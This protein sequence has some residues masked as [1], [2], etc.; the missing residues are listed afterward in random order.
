V[1]FSYLLALAATHRA[2]CVDD[3]GPL[4]A[5][6]IFHALEAYANYVEL[7]PGD[8]PR[9]GTWGR[10]AIAGGIVRNPAGD[11][12]A[13]LTCGITAFVPGLAD[14]RGFEVGARGADVVAAYGDARAACQD[15]YEGHT[16]C[17]FGAFDPDEAPV[18][19]YIVD[20]PPPATTITD[21]DAREYLAARTVRAVQVRVYC[22]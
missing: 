2:P 8:T 3:A 16:E 18:S 15:D 12:I 19:H 7:M 9:D 1:W 6:E 5:A 13:E 10:C 14:E 21:D 4:D 17:W 20:G 22:H 11:P